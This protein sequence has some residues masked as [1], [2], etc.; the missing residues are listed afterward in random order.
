[1]ELKLILLL[2]L[3][4][5]LFGIAQCEA[6]INWKYSGEITV[7]EKPKG[8]KIVSLKNDQKNENFL[9]LEIIEETDNLF[10]VNIS[11][12]MSSE[13]YKGWIKKDNYIGAIV[14]QEKEFMNLVLYDK[15]SQKD[16]KKTE[17]KK[18]K[19]EFI[20]IIKCEGNWT[21][22]SV[23]YKGKRTVGWIESDKLC[24]NNYST[25]S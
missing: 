4:I 5:P 22:V 13:S 12:A 14:R 15:P 10:N 2:S 7:Y 24:A 19:S 25:C 20:T 21:F 6:I 11:L 1:M 23:S 17:L 16:S 9:S 8:E 18:W 3:L